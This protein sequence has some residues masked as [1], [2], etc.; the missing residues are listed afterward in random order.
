M[1]KSIAL[2]IFYSEADYSKQLLRIYEHSL[3]LDAI[4]WLIFNQL[5][6]N[7]R[8]LEPHSNF[9]KSER[10]RNFLT[11]FVHKLETKTLIFQ[12]PE[13]FKTS[14]NLR[15]RGVCSQLPRSQ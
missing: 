9:L 8:A 11:C 3:L 4:S 7:M 14:L 15:N 6:K 10:W 2:L 1:M 13:I 5:L 12:K